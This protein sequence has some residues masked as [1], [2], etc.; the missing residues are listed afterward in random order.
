M[1]TELEAKFLDI[2]ADALRSVLK[3]HGATLV[4]S[5]RFMR[6]KNFDYAD[7]RL[8]KIGGWVRLRDEGDK[9]TLAYKQLLDRTLEG[10]KEISTTVGDF[11]TTTDLL[12]AIG[13]VSTSYQETKRERLDFKGVE[14]T[15]DTW[16]WIPTF[17]ELEGPTEK[18]LKETALV[19]GLEWD[20]AIHG[21][22]EN[23]Y[24]AYYDISEVDVYG[25]EAIRFGPVP[26]YFEE[27]RRR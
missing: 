4:H 19:L 9:V 2:D 3:T 10:T 8:E 6:R 11:E 22:V 5:E 15:I 14:V 20:K 24:Q 13:L 7:K 27:R 23:A 18:A 1:H 12:L 17:V 26:K 21:S 25:L 16:P